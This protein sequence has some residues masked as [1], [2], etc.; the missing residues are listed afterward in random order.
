MKGKYGT[1]L[2]LEEIAKKH[3]HTLEQHI[4][5]NIEWILHETACD[6]KQAYEWLVCW[7][8][9]DGTKDNYKYIVKQY[10]NKE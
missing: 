5:F 1:R 10:L 3:N 6:W 9:E 7:S 4:V 2:Q 8:I